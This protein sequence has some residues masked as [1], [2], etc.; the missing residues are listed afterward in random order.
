MVGANETT[1]LR[2]PPNSDIIL[3]PENALVAVTKK[4][5]VPLVVDAAAAAMRQKWKNRLS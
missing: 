5:L 3:V 4:I 1:E 2:R